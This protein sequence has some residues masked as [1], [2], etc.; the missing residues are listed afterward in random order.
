M[1]KLTII[2]KRKEYIEDKVV[3]KNKNLNDLSL[4]VI[5]LAE[6]ECFGTTYTITKE[7]EVEEDE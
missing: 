4:L 2:Q 3:F 5:R 6:N 1:W 7:E